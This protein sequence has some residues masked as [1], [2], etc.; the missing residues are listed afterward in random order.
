METKTISEPCKNA[1]RNV[2]AR[3]QLNTLASED[4]K[5]P[6]ALPCTVN[7]CQQTKVAVSQSVIIKVIST[8]NSATQLLENVGVSISLERR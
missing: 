1:R 6:L 5:K 2:T 8:T 3:K 4:F 7:Q